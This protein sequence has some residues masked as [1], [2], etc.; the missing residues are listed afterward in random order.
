MQNIIDTGLLFEHFDDSAWFGQSLSPFLRE[1]ARPSAEGHSTAPWRWVDLDATRRCLGAAWDM[2]G[3]WQARRAVRVS[4]SLFDAA[5]PPAIQAL[6]QVLNTERVSCLRDLADATD[7]KAEAVTQ[8]V[9]AA[10]GTISRVKPTKVI[11]PMFGSKVVH[12]YFPSVVPAFD[13]AKVRDGGMRS[14]AYFDFED[15]DTVWAER[16]R[17]SESHGDALDEFDW[18]FTFCAAQITSAPIDP[19]TATRQE[20][21]RRCSEFAPALVSDRDSLLWKLDA[22]IAEFCAVGLA[23]REDDAGESEVE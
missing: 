1:Q 20:L 12:H 19:L 14:T 13:H 16:A 15:G 18:W 10:V 7:A 22:K 11:S 4:R 9:I 6:A 21:G 5:V 3:K 23:A 17:G 2:L 8:A